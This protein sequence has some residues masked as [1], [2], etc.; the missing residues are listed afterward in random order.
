MGRGVEWEK[1]EVHRGFARRGHWW[2]GTDGLVACPAGGGWSGWV[3]SVVRRGSRARLMA[4]VL[5][6]VGLCLNNGKVIV[7]LTDVRG[8]VGCQNRGRVVDG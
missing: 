5:K 2:P 7:R 6:S 8:L 3:V 1:C 4:W